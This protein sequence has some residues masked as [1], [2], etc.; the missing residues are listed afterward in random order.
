MLYIVYMEPIRVVAAST[1]AEL[2]KMTRPA[3]QRLFDAGVLGR[4]ITDG[5]RTFVYEQSVKDLAAMPTI[6]VADLPP[7]LILKVSAPAT[8]E[9][10]RV[11]WNHLEPDIAK[12]REPIL[13]WWPVAED[14][15]LGGHL[16]VVTVSGVVV[17][18]SRITSVTHDGRA[19]FEVEEAHGED[20]EAWRGQRTKPIP[21]G[22]THRNYI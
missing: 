13:Q 17:D 6:N 21:G 10:R 1:A 11:G 15:D 4:T 8:L 9:G 2:L 20:A 7:A 12:R 22:L 18:V 5:Q 14:V 19:A 3:T 16:L